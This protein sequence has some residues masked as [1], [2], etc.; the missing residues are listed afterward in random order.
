MNRFLNQMLV[1]GMMVALV[2]PSAVA[3]DK[4]NRDLSANPL[5][6]V[7]SK[8]PDKEL[9][10][11]AMQ[12]LKK[13]RFDVARL[14]LQTL[15]NTYPDSEYQM[16][17]KLSIGD[18]WF[19][20]GGTAALTQAEAEYKDFITFFPQAPEAAEAQMKVADIYYMQMEKPD[21]DFNNTL[22]SEQEYRNMIQQFPESP[23]VPRA[24]QRL[25]E[26]QEVLAEREYQIG[27]FYASHENWDA[28]IARLQTIED[29]YPLYSHSDQVLLTLG[30][31]YEATARQMER[32]NIAP[33]A[34]KQLVSTYDDRAAAAY[35]KVIMRYPMAP[36]VEE[37]RDRLVALN[38]QIP[39]PTQEALAANDAEE[40]SRVGVRLTDRMLGLVKHGPSTVEAPRVGEPTLASPART[41]APQITHAKVDSYNAAMAGKPA[42]GQQPVTAA[43]TSDGTVP[44]RTESPAAPLQLENPG[45]GNGGNA[46]GAT[47]ISAPNSASTPGNG[48]G[49]GASQGASG[50]PSAAP[51]TPATP[52]DFGI[53]QTPPANAALPA[54]EKPADA[55]AQINDVKNPPPAQVNTGATSADKKKAKKPAFDSSAESSSKHKKKKGLDKINPF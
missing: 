7:D 36:H 13:G 55:P 11:K 18:S 4:K 50:G 51:G 17:A 1:A 2:A 12:A 52:E 49:T 53:K 24:K 35:T 38:R 3:K 20:E 6:K 37:A 30:D 26:V 34:K 33:A 15:L 46:V 9:Y 40:R 5:S 25:R 10:D 44:P 27:A 21:R 16:R 28:T 31:A 8:Q 48:A 43:A 22:R 32:L 45:E 14:D 39:E 42:E 47:I 54:T 41:L 23:L 29:T 19:K